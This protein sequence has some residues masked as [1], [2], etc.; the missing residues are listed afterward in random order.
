MSI[1]NALATLFLILILLGGCQEKKEETTPITEQETEK[2]E[3]QQG[4]SITSFIYQLQNINL[5]ELAKANADLLIIDYSPDGTDER[6]FSRQQIQQ[7]KA[8]GKTVIAYISIGEAENYRWYWRQEWDSDE[9]GTPEAT[10]PEWLGKEN[11][12]WKGNYKTKHWHKDWQRIIY[13][14]EQSYMDK[15]ISAGFDGAYMDIIDAY[16]YWGLGGESGLERKTSKQEMVGF[17]KTISSHAKAKKE[18][19]KIFVQNG[20][21]LS[22]HPDYIAAVDGIGA[23][24]V[25][26]N[27][28]TKQPEERTRTATEHLDRFK[29]AGKNVLVID[30]PQSPEKIEDFKAKSRTKGYIPYA[31][32]R[33]LDST[34]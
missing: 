33:S 28:E 8:S 27:D 15:I 19:F 1:K 4:I 10:A 13:G 25:F 31:A 34:R 12:D 26:Y 7:I 14:T 5:E 24:D 20:E 18:G 29:A 32:Q 23:E 9:D 3:E 11:P 16:Q 2:T 21:E 17:V 30:Y 6:R 22:T